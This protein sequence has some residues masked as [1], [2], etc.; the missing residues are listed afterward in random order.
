MYHYFVQQHLKNFYFLG[1]DDNIRIGALKLY[2]EL[3]DDDASSIDIQQLIPRSFHRRYIA[4]AHDPKDAE[5][6]IIKKIFNEFDRLKGKERLE[7]RKEILSIIR[8]R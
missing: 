4:E 5:M 2:S 7:T 6:Q 1:K 8:K 3:E